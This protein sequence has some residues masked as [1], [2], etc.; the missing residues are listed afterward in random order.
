MPPPALPPPPEDWSADLR[1]L[2]PAAPPLNNENIRKRAADADTTGNY[3]L[4]KGPADAGLHVRP[5]FDEAVLEARLVASDPLLDLG[6]RLQ[7]WL[8]MA[9]SR[10]ACACASRTRPTAIHASGSRRP[11][12]HAPTFYRNG[13]A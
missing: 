1:A 2:G 13:W 12:Q 7:S 5:L 6:Q 4:S 11:W 10:R 9:A 3:G 8:A